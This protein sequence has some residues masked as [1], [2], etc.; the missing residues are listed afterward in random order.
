MRLEINY[1]KKNGEKNNKHTETK[2]YKKTNVSM[3]KSEN[4]L[5]QCKWRHNF[6]KFMGCSKS[7]SERKIYSNIYLSQEILIISSKQSNL[8]SKGIRKRRT[9]T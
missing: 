8:P 1:R 9:K 4:T 2:Q 7:S 5:I 6:Q 3:R